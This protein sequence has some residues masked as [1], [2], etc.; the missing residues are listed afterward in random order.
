MPSTHTK[1]LG[2]V[3]YIYNPNTG[4]AETRR[5]LEFGD[6]ST[7]ASV[8]ETLFQKLNKKIESS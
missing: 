7:S 3:V 4:E 1:T 2:V 8:R 5:F 6:E